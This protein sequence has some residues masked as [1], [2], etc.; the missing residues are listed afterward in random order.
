MN[1]PQWNA[2]EISMQP[3]LQSLR[4][5]RRIQKRLR[6]S[7]SSL[8]SFLFIFI[9]ACILH[10]S[11]NPCKLISIKSLHH[12]HNNHFSNISIIPQKKRFKRGRSLEV[13]SF[14]VSLFWDNFEWMIHK[15]GLMNFYLLLRWFQ[16]PKHSKG[17]EEEP[18]IL[19]D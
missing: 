4:R 14:H 19:D 6:A 5:L 15:Q 3:H 7:S 18:S 17:T 12:L 1:K 2:A 9:H 10:V 13:S 16:E 11:I 8:L